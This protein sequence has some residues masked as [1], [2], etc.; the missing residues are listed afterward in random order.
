MASHPLL[1]D[2]LTNRQAAILSIGIA[3]ATIAI[4]IAVPVALGQPP[5][6]FRIACAVAFY[7]PLSIN[8]WIDARNHVLLK[9]WTHLAYGIWF[10]A[11][12]LGNYPVSSV[13]WAIAVGVPVVAASKFS[14]GRL[15]GLGDVRLLVVLAGW[16][17][18]WAPWGTLTMLAIA[19]GTHGLYLLMRSL[20]MRMTLRDRHPLGPWLVAGSWIAW[21]LTG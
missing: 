8:A 10:I 21:A 12:F 13:V 2:S 4:G 19:F 6:A 15:I 5:Q 16:N 20:R 7:I 11:L 17:G 9:N 3:V 18:L 14:G 1:Y